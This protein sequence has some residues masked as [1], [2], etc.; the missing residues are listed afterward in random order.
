MTCPQEAKRPAHRESAEDLATSTH[1]FPFSVSRYQCH[2]VFSSIPSASAT[3]RWCEV[4]WTEAITSSA[5]AV[6]LRPGPFP[7]KM[8]RRAR[9]VG[10]D[11]TLKSR[12][13]DTHSSQ[14]SETGNFTEVDKTFG[15]RAPGWSQLFRVHDSNDFL[16]VT[17]LCWTCRKP[18]QERDIVTASLVLANIRIFHG[19]L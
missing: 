17:N 16:T 15:V 8:R 12:E 11:S 2:S 19:K 3:R 10:S 18:S 4:F 9:R 6:T 1:H 7:S 14:L 5:S 13:R